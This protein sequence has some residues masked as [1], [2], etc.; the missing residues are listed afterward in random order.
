MIGAALIAFAALSVV[1]SA[2]W[3]NETGLWQATVIYHP[4][5]GRS[6]YNLGNAYREMNDPTRA[7]QAYRKATQLVQDEE[8][9]FRAYANL[10]TVLARSGVEDL[11]LEYCEKALALRPAEPALLRLYGNL[12][13]Q[14]GRLDEAVAALTEAWR[15]SPQTADLGHDLARTL[16]KYDPPKIDEATSVYRRALDGGAPAD[17]KIEAKL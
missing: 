1:Y 3:R 7:V 9:R 2:M 15:L 13:A 4:E 16:L 6:Y 10:G 12:L 8:L 5:C 14:K 17:P 11:A